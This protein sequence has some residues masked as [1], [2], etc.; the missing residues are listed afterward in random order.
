MSIYNRGINLKE[1]YN[2]KFGS[3]AVS[4]IS[5]NS[6]KTFIF[7]GYYNITIKL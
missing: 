6:S 5:S 2:I 3:T 1:E 7:S 4:N